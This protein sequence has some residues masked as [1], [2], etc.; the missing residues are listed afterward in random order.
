MRKVI[1][2]IQVTLD[3]F[4][5]GPNGEL[6]WAIV[7][8]ELHKH[9]NDQESRYDFHLYGRRLY[10]IMSAFWPTADEDP[11]VPDYVIE[12]AHIWKEMPKI[13]FSKSL[14][15]VEWNSRLVKGDAGEEIRKL[16]SQPGKDLSIGGAEFASSMLKLG[17]I[18]ECEVY[19]NPIVLGSGKR[20]FTGFENPVDLQLLETYTFGSG[21]VRLRY[22]V[23]TE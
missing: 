23:E 8:E 20:I 1:Y 19:V 9:F 12:Y 6:D 18:D 17:L 14:D 13:V 4:F 15:K 21:V 22:R 5:E 7:D 2:A 10:E 3:G 11:T 16:K